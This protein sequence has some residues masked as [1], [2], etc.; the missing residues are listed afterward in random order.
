M[1][2]AVEIRSIE[3][4]PHPLGREIRVFGRYVR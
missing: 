4:V 2:M 3:I 1:R